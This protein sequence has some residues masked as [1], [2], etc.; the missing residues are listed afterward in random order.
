MTQWPTADQWFS[1]AD[2]AKCELLVRELFDVPVN[3]RRWQSISSDRRAPVFTSGQTEIEW[4][5]V[6]AGTFEFGLSV[7]EQEQALALS[8]EP[9]LTFDEMKP[10]RLASMAP[11]LIA[12]AP[13]PRRFVDAGAGE[14]D[15]TEI[16]GPNDSWLCDSDD[17]AHLAETM[18]ASIPTELEWEYACRGGSQS[19]FWFGERVPRKSSEMERILGLRVPEIPNGFGL[20]SLFFGEW[21]SDIWKKDLSPKTVPDEAAGPVIRG[22]GARFWPWQDSREWSGC[23]SAYRLSKEEA[24]G[25]GAAVRLVRRM[26]TPKSS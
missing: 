15:E 11:F 17:A 6:P 7:A 21:C 18:Q 9:F 22:G 20:V 24:G 10:V 1:H 16:I 12:L 8:E 13:V 4:G 25:A 5:L 23:V 26:K 14:P 3:F 2:P 19:L